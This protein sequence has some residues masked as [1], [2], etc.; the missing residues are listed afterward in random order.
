MHEGKENLSKKEFSTKN[1]IFLL[2][3]KAEYDSPRDLSARHV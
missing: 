2:G 3:M 1:E